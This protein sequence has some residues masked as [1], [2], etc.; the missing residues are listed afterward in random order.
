MLTLERERSR[1]KGFGILREPEWSGLDDN[2]AGYDVLSY[3]HGPT[4]V[5]NRLIEVKSTIV[6]PLRFYITRQE[7]RKAKSTGGRY[8]FHTWDMSK[9]P[10]VLHTRSV[11]EVAI[12]RTR[13]LG[14]FGA[15]ARGQR[16]DYATDPLY[17]LHYGSLGMGPTKR[18]QKPTLNPDA[19][20]VHH[21]RGR[22]S[23]FIP[24]AL[25]LEDCLLL[26][27]NE[28]DTNWG[29]DLMHSTAVSYDWLKDSNLEI[30]RHQFRVPGPEAKMNRATP[31]A[32]LQ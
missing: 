10:P 27:H 23:A 14:W 29:L 25:E 12:G 1:L 24:I 5:V 13:R 28:D 32:E 30:V 8:I 9:E 31:R 22:H 15:R 16:M 6:S 17:G 3:E 11:A 4:G 7:W 19:R 18:F 21:S 26:F 20:F 2:F